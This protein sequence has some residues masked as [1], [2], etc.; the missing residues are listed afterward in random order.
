MNHTRESVVLILSNIEVI[1]R[2]LSGL[3]KS[4]NIK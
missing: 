1:A 4:Q 3:S 2:M